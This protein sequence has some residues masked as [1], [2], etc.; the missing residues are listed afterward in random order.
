MCVGV[1]GERSDRTRM[2]VVNVWNT[3]DGALLGD[4][5]GGGR[6]C[7]MSGHM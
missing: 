3:A 2:V 6:A 5:A 1:G 7:A 4:G